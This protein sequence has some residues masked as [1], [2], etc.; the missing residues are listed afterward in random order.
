MSPL[1]QNLLSIR[2]CSLF[3]APFRPIAHALVNHFWACQT[4][5]KCVEHH[6]RRPLS[7]WLVVGFFGKA[8]IKKGTW[9]G[10]LLPT[11]TIFVNTFVPKL[12]SFLPFLPGTFSIQTWASHTSLVEE[13]V[14]HF[15]HFRRTTHTH[16]HA[17]CV[18]MV[19][20]KGL[21]VFGV[22]IASVSD[23]RQHWFSFFLQVCQNKNTQGVLWICS[24]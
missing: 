22:Q 1:L 13:A 23:S 19:I 21:S 8:I 11:C 15:F 17:H 20:V 4:L 7:V 16:T 14:A 9:K 2:S 10:Q 18:C 6:R 24:S 12:L 5:A 3:F